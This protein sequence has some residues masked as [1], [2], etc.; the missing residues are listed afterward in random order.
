MA[1]ILIIL[2]SVNLT[3]L[4]DRDIITA[5]LNVKL[6]QLVESVIIL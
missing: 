2:D 3:V 1:I 4:T 5:Q 6:A